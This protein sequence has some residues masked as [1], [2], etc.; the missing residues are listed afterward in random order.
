MAL[1]ARFPPEISF[2]SWCR[3]CSGSN[4]GAMTPAAWPCMWTA[5]S[6]PA[7]PHAWPNWLSRW[8]RPKLQ[9]TTGIAHTRWAT[10][11]APAVHNAHPHFSHGT[12]ADAYDRPGRIALVHNGII[13]NHDELRASLDRQGLCVPEPDRY[14]GHRA[15]GRQPVRRRPVRGRPGARRASC[16][17]P[18]RSRCSARTNRSA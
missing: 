4:T 16:A 14:R 5:C 3:A 12:G 10:H 2:R 7:A 1:L 6:V 8:P 13:E 18:M 15:P 11:G 17:A 9:G